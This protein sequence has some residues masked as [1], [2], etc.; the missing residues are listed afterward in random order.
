[1]IPEVVLLQGGEIV[2]EI[3]LGVVGVNSESSTILTLYNKG[4]NELIDIKLYS[5]HPDVT[6]SNIPQNLKAKE[7]KDFIVKYKPDKELDKG[8]TTDIIIQGGYVV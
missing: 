6:F 5:N 8:I 1:M 2:E 3:D 7:K 4:D